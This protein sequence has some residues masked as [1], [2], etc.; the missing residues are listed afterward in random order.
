M[1]VAGLGGKAISSGQIGFVLAPRLNAAGRLGKTMVS[2]RL[3][4]T[5]NPFEAERLALELCDLN[6]ERQALEQEIWD[7]ASERAKASAPGSPLVLSSD[8]WHQGVIGIAAS[9]LSETYS[10]PAIMISLDGDKG[11]GSCRSYGGFNLFDALS[12][13]GDLL[14]AF[15]GH[16][17]AAGLNI[18]RGNIE[19]FRQALSRYYAEH[20]PTAMPDLS[21]DV[22]ITDPEMLSHIRI[23]GTELLA[24][25]PSDP[26]HARNDIEGESVFRLPADSPIIAGAREALENLDIL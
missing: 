3:L 1:E 16:A 4:M 11:K 23:E 25:I 22:L 2:A 10:V 19:A 20:P 7:E 14:D 26:A 18:S 5:K 24:V 9:R 6:R 15:G 12:A 21:P 8:D 13:C 17:L